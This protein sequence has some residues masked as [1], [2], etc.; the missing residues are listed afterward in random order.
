MDVV[1]DVRGAEEDGLAGV[2]RG[3]EGA[4]HG[5]GWAGSVSDVS[6]YESACESDFEGGR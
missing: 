1:E 4:A 6:H 2:V 3:E 5:T